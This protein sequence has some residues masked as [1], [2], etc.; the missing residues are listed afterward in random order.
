LGTIPDVGTVIV[1][2]VGCALP[3]NTPPG[4][5]VAKVCVYVVPGVDIVMLP[6]TML[7]DPVIVTLTRDVRLVPKISVT[8]W[9]LSSFPD[10][11]CGKSEYV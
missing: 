4:V 1:V 5:G 8:I 10:P 9:I 6:R 7:V 2:I 11:G 3:L